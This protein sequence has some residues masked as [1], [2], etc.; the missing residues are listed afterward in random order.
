MKIAALTQV[1]HDDF[2]LDIWI[3]HYAGL[4]GR[5]NC[6]IILDGDDWEP[7]ADT[8]GTNIIVKP[9]DTFGRK[10]VD[11][12][13]NTRRAE[14]MQHIFGE[15]GYTH[16]IISD[17]DEITVLDPQAGLSFEDCLK[18]MNDRGYTYSLGMD[19]V[20]HPDLD[21][22]L[23][24]EKPILSQRDHVVVSRSYSKVNVVSRP[25]LEG[26]LQLKPGMHKL[27]GGK[28]YVSPGLNVL[29]FGLVDE[30]PMRQRF[31]NRTAHDP[32]GGFERWLQ[33]RIAF[34]D[35]VKDVPPTD[36]APHIE[37]LKQELA[38]EGGRRVQWPRDF[39]GNAG[40]ENQY[41]YARLNGYFGEVI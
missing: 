40:P 39:S 19:V 23:D 14:Q 28:V 12:Q 10:A 7:T 11:V 17:C 16:V 5:E 4:I 3:R 41:L 30:A 27:R 6:F 38:F 1:R 37:R 2:F 29:H 22:P 31:R 33:G 25:W 36:Y 32:R 20:Q 34:F 9:R 21:A 15:L 26:G 18:E 24:P 8:A 13:S 35:S